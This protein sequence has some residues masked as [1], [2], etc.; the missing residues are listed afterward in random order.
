MVGTHSCGP[1]MST[2]RF[3]S[4][5][6][7]TVNPL[8][9]FLRLASGGGPDAGTDTKTSVSLTSYPSDVRLTPTFP[10]W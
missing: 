3:L 10:E 7:G 1:P 9:Y 4:M 8:T 5:A 6:S 2:N